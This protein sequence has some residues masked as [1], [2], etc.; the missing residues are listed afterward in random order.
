MTVQAGAAARVVESR[1]AA[2]RE[3]LTDIQ[4]AGAHAMDELRRLLVVLDS[5]DDA[6]PVTTA[7]PDWPEILDDARRTGLSVRFTSDDLAGVEPGVVLTLQRAL[8]EA[9]VNARRHGG[10]CEVTACLRRQADRVTLAV[11]DDGAGV[12]EGGGTGHGLAG[13][14]ERVQMYGGAIAAGAR[15][16]GGWLLTVSL[17]AR[18]T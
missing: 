13:L 16:G 3:A 1:P 14:R 8:H 2:A 15:E 18:T 6:A 4:R 17:P 9:L 10:E 11:E 5:P 7:V 12:S